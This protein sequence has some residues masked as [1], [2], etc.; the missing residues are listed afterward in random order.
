M[1]RLPWFLIGFALLFPAGFLLFQYGR[2]LWDPLYLQFTG[3]KTVGQAV[4]TLGPE[5][6]QKLAPAF[7]KSRFDLSP[8]IGRNI[9]RFMLK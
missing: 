6:K 1:K 9:L 4:K 5:I 8:P 2:P 3:Q 7:K